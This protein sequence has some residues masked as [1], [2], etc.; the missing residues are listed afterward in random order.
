MEHFSSKHF[1][2][3]AFELQLLGKGNGDEVEVHGS[4]S[5]CGNWWSKKTQRATHVVSGP[6]GHPGASSLAR[7][8]NFVRL[9]WHINLVMRSKENACCYLLAPSGAMVC[10]S[11]SLSPLFSLC[12]FVAVNILVN[13]D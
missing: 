4:G 2:N 9:F 10:F 11:I 5:G 1:P 3:K 12:A 8:L 6:H 13:F 7:V